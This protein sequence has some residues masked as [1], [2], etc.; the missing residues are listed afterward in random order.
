MGRRYSVNGNCVNAASA[1]L[2]LGIVTG[3]AAVR[4]QIYDIVLGS[5]ATPADNAAKYAIQRAT[6]AGT[7]AGAGGA[8]ITPQALDPADPA[9]VTTANQG[10]ASVGPTLTAAAFLLQFPLNQRATFRWVAAPGSE[11]RIPATANNGLALLSLVNGGSSVNTAFCFL[12]E[13]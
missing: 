6:T 9:A 4:T 11:L 1:T 7:W 12:I 2:P 3:T 13:E 5:D 10:I 8:A